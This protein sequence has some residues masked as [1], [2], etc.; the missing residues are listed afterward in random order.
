MNAELLKL[1]PDSSRNT[2]DV[3]ASFILK[4]PAYL[5]DIF[6][7]AFSD[8]QKI[9]MRASRIIYLVFEQAPDLIKPRFSE[10][11]QRLKKI[12]DT[13][14]KRN[15]IHLF[16]N[17]TSLLNEDDLGLL[18]DICFK[19]IESPDSEVAHKIYSIYLIYEVSNSIPELKPE[20]IAII[21]RNIDTEQTAYKSTGK[22]MLKK[23]YKE[24][25]FFEPLS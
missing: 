24:T 15:L 2:A 8:K 16:I 11:L 6:E 22:R 12:T 10:I 1:L 4:N 5:D 21:E 18:L 14:A 19:Y 17:N 25:T 13:S 9:A 23:L 3:A 20:L 7:L